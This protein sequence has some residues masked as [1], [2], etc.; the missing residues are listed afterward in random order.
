MMKKILFDPG[1][2]LPHWA[3]LNRQI[4]ALI[5]TPLLRDV[6]QSQ[7]AVSFLRVAL[8]FSLL[9]ATQALVRLLQVMPSRTPGQTLLTFLRTPWYRPALALLAL[10]VVVLAAMLTL[11]I[12][13]GQQ[14]GILNRL[15]NLTLYQ[16]FGNLAVLAMIV[17]LTLI[18]AGWRRFILYGPP[19]P[20]GFYSRGTP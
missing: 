10:G 20:A 19:E 14:G 11:Q 2:V 18:L 5:N 3:A 17:G 9:I 8:I 4:D 1:M 13:A 6:H 16:L 15:S 12:L 7:V